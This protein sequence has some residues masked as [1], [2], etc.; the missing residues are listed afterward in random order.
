MTLPIIN[1]KYNGNEEA[2][3]LTEIIEQKLSVLEKFITDGAA[4]T[5]DVEF[6]K[7]TAQQQ[8]RIFRV[9]V[10]LGVNGELFRADATEE[11]FER[12]IDVVQNKLDQELRRAKEKN[13]T[14]HKKGGRTLK[15]FLTS[16]FSGK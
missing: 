2:K 3:N 14:N 9:E 6:E 5:C 13:E 16:T 11:S 10:N 15:E 8:G 1:Y 4:L 12:A 7:V